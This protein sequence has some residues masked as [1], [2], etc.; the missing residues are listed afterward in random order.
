MS[1]IF[2]GQ[3]VPIRLHCSLGACWLCSFW[4]PNKSISTFSNRVCE[5]SPC[6]LPKSLLSENELSSCTPEL[7]SV[8]ANLLHVFPP[9]KTFCRP[10]YMLLYFLHLLQKVSCLLLKSKVS[11]LLAIP[12]LVFTRPLLHQIPTL[13]NTSLRT[14]LFVYNLSNP[15]LENTSSFQLASL[16]HCQSYCLH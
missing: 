15:F 5:N 13:N 2:P 9:Y 4:S 6:C 7:W 14:F 8:G 16:W 12:A 10:F 3:V 1:A 11:L